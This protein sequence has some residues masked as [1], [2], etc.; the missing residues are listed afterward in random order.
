MSAITLFDWVVIILYLIGITCLGLWASRKVHSSSSLFIGDRQ[1]GKWLMTFHT[2][3]TGTHSDQAVGVAAKAYST[4]AAGIWYQWLW[5]FV[6]PF[7]W[8]IAPIFRR[9]R[10]VTVG[11]YFEA[12]YGGS[13][14]VLFAVVG[15][16]QLM[17]SIGLML[18]GSSAMIGA[19]SGGQIDPDWAIGAMTVMFVVY[20][21]AGGLSAAIITD[22]VQG[23]MTIL[24]SF[25][26]LPFALDAVGGM[27]GL[28]ASINNPAFF[29]LVAPGEIGVFFVG[30]IALNALIGWGC[31]PTSMGMCSAGKSEM[32]GRVGVTAGVLI[33]RVCTIAWVLTG[34]CAVALYQGQTLDVDHVYGK[35]ARDLFPT[36]GPGL[37]GLFLAS[38]L[39]SVMSSCD[40]LMIASSALFTQNVYRK[41]IAPGKSD[42][43]FLWVGR[44]ASFCIV[45]V[46]VFFA[47]SIESVVS[48]LE[49]FWKLSAMM[50]IAFWVGLF[51]RRGSPAGAWAG[52]LVSFATL[53]FA[54]QITLIGWDFNDQLASY[55]PAFML[56]EGKLYLPWQMIMY[57]VTGLVA[58]IGV[59][60]VTRPMAAESL[61]RLFACL[62]T[63]IQP[64]ERET[65]AFTLPEGLAPEPRRPL[66][67]HPDFEIPRP[68]VVGVVG[69]FAAWI[70]VG[71]LMGSFV[72][73]L[74][75]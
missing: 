24:L 39:A 32:E 50:G 3:G 43:H 34:L 72:W 53:L 42:A 26:L 49:T 40:S 33:K 56:W 36:I 47:F 20:G 38:M 59:S 58:F 27:D 48:G 30:V 18:K 46:G 71:L 67:N 5:L 37:I 6:T 7:Y 64:W 23:L 62:R 52:T 1:F 54:S 15:I 17:F 73:I 60:L 74:A 25:L 61:D 31:Q 45:L 65:Q 51:W 66:I 69:F 22:F 44:I 21:V 19:V 16:G 4:G 55:L 12:R 10:A 11:E 28:R 2:F 9:M 70:A 75:P 41:L 63:P 29:E 13:V 35:M 68:S 8:V 57:L 14:A